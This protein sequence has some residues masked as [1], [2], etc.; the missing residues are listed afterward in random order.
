MGNVGP[1]LGSVGSVGN[2]G[3]PP[4]PAKWI[5]S[6]TMLIGRLEIFALIAIL[7]PAQWK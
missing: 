5:L 2:F 1:G 7:V 4:A 3:H 6:A